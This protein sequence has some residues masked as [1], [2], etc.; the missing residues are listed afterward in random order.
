MLE[1]DDLDP[2]RRAAVCVRIGELSLQMA[3]I[4]VAVSYL[5]QAAPVLGSNADFVLTYAEA[6][7]RAGDIEPA[8]AMLDGLLEKEPSHAAARALRRR[9]R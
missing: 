8:R 2:R 7:W 9:M 3:D 4:A 1:G 6:R 5:E